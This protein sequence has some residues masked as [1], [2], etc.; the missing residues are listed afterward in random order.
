MGGNEVRRREFIAL[1]GAG[2]TWPFAAM[3]Q[4]PGRTYRLGALQPIPRDTPVQNSFFDA[5]RSHGFIEGQN[6]IVDYRGGDRNRRQGRQIMDC[7][8]ISF[9]NSPLIWSV[10]E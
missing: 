9:Q 8:S 5:L 4:E 6:L 1:A 10:P 3:A 2:V 7:T